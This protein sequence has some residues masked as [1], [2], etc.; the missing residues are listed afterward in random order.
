M[1]RQVPAHLLALPALTQEKTPMT[2]AL[3]SP[4]C[5]L[6]PVRQEY[7]YTLTDS[8]DAQD[9]TQWNSLRLP[10][11]DPHMDPRFIRT[12]ERSM[13]H[14]ARFWSVLVRDANQRP[15]ASACF[16]LYRVDGSLFMEGWA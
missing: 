15:V 5:V 6:S 9:E 3:L 2:A 10:G 4:A 8:I 16:C 11:G 12:V 13:A 14:E 7:S 1:P